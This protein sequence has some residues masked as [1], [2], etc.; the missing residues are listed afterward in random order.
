M[1]ALTVLRKGQH[2]PRVREMQTA[3]KAKGYPV[4][5][6]GF[7]GANTEL[8]LIAFQR[9]SGL[10]PDGI[11]GQRTLQLL[12][13]RAL[14]TAGAHPPGPAEL[15][16]RLGAI[17]GAAAGAAV[18]QPVPPGPSKPAGACSTSQE[19]LRFL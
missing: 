16:G 9:R 1:N 8:T 17:V 11:A 6:D 15:T 5:A 13:L 3:L 18:A 2:S 7:F 10:L 19:G 14:Q 12:G 4:N